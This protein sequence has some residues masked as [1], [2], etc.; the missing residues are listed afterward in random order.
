MTPEVEK[1]T[2]EVASATPGKTMA[3]VIDVKGQK[4]HWTFAANN[5]AKIVMRAS[6][7]STM[8]PAE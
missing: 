5:C 2:I 4:D 8:Q 1:D 7:N 6:M 3:T